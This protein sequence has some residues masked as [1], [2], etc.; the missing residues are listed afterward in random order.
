M[1]WGLVGFFE[2]LS[3]RRIG[4]QYAFCRDGAGLCHGARLPTDGTCSEGGQCALGIT[5]RA[6]NHPAV[7]IRTHHPGYNQT[8][9]GIHLIAF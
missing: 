8:A 2:S 6:L 3:I 9:A 4:H 1:V 7:L 5:L